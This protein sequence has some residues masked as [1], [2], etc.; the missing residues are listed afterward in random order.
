[1]KTILHQLRAAATAA[2]AALLFVCAL[3]QVA[4]AADTRLVIRRSVGYDVSYLLSDIVALTYGTDDL[5]VT[6]SGGTDTF[7][8]STIDRVEFALDGTVTGIGDAGREPNPIVSSHLFQNFP[9]PFNPQTQIAF[10][11]PSAG[12]AE[13]RIYDVLGRLVRTLV[14]EK[15][16]AGYQI[17]R[18]DGRDD[19]GR[20]VASGMYFYR[21]LAPG[22]DESRKMVVVR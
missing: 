1:M 6:T 12:L 19:D 11:L 5:N 17:L 15:R 14:D 20:V 2:A 9:N 13:I 16:P 3:S 21:L 10:D 8:L 7:P 22:V 18:W 4:V